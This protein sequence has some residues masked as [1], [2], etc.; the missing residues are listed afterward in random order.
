MGYGG[1]RT[2]YS[3]PGT[4]ESAPPRPRDD[5][6]VN[7]QFRSRTSHLPILKFVKTATPPTSTNHQHPLHVPSA[8]PRQRGRRNNGTRCATRPA[9]SRN[10]LLCQHGLTHERP[11]SPFDRRRK[12]A[13]LP[14]AAPPVGPSATNT[15]PTGLQPSR[16]PPEHCSSHHDLLTNDPAGPSAQTCRCTLAAPAVSSRPDPNPNAQP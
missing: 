3:A 15:R 16:V 13:H 12:H 7:D 4:L 9:R 11:R 8:G 2:V 6:A 10:S 14:L 1:R 5:A